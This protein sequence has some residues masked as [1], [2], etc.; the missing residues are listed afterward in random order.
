MDIMGDDHVFLKWSVS[1]GNRFGE[2]VKAMNT[3]SFYYSKYYILIS[4]DTQ[5]A[6]SHTSGA[7]TCAAEVAMVVAV[8]A[9]PTAFA[10]GGRKTTCTWDF[11]LLRCSIYGMFT[12]IWPRFTTNVGR[13]CIHGGFSFEH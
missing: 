4:K 12:Y 5:K 10:P 1:W 13:Y 11:H 9:E 6:P 2:E 3:M 8:T 7:G